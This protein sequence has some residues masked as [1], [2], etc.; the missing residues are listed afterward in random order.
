MKISEIYSSPIK[1]FSVESDRLEQ[2]HS[3]LEKI[4]PEDLTLYKSDHNG[5][6]R[7]EN[8]S[9]E[10]ASIKLQS[11][12]KNLYKI[13]DEE[14]LLVIASDILPGQNLVRVTKNPFRNII[15]KYINK[16][17]LIKPSLEFSIL[18]DGAK[19]VPHTDSTNK[20]ITLM[21]YFPTQDQEGRDD[22][23][24][25][26]HTFPEE[27]QM[28]YENNANRHYTPELYPNFYKD[29]TELYRI[30]F[31]KG[32]IYGFVKGSHSWHSLPPV[33]LRPSEFRRSLN[34]NVYMY[35]QS[36]FWPAF[37][38][39]IMRTKLIAKRIIKR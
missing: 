21:M 17:V 18:K 35:K 34:I 1:I 16:K 28:L 15:N 11:E 26:F 38:D 10:M 13:L 5:K 4:F 19:L 36:L 8:D 14:I 30:P 37:N 31:T 22:L 7:I 39:I 24:T 29:S 23:G 27:K 12:W 25:V 32:A 33:K 9:L 20:I 3:S 6:F 2:M